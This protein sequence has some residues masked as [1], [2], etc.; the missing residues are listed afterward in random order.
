[1]INKF[2]PTYFSDANCS[3][4]QHIEPL[5]SLQGAKGCARILASGCSAWHRP[6]GMSLLV[7]AWPSLPTS[8][9]ADIYRLEP[10]VLLLWLQ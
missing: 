2:L 10:L 3:M 9:H 1:M 4:R 7:K 5:S 8:V 6:R